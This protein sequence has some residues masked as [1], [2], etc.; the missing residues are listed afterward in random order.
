MD[1]IACGKQIDCKLELAGLTHIFF[2]LHNLAP[3]AQDQLH[4]SYS[5]EK[6]Y[7][8]VQYHKIMAKVVMYI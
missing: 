3:S 2:G 4:L 7:Q 8:V 1:D 5:A 6:H